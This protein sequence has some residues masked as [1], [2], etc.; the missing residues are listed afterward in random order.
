ML[1]VNIG[2]FIDFKDFRLVE[3]FMRNTNSGG[4][5]RLGPTRKMAGNLK[6]EWWMR[7]IVILH[8]LDS[9]HEV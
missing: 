5:E 7:F 2:D 9:N 6:A 8:Y 4:Q 3:K 1:A